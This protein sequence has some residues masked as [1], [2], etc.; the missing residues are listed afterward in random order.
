MSNKS[1][2]KK[3]TRKDI[4]FENLLSSMNSMEMPEGRS[5]DDTWNMLLDNIEH[6][7]TSKTTVRK[8]PAKS[9]LSIAASVIIIVGSWIAYNNLHMQTY[10]AGFGQITEVILP[11][12]SQVKLNAGT[13]IKFNKNRWKNNRHILINGEALFIVTKGNKFSVESDGKMI[14]VLGTS[15]NVLSRDNRFEVQCYT[16]KVSVEISSVKPLLLEKGEAVKTDENLKTL[17]KYN[18]DAGQ[19]VKWTKGEFYFNQEKLEYV[20]EEI[21]RQ[22]NVSIKSAEIKDRLYTGYFRKGSLKTALDIVCMPMGITYEM[23]D[24]THINIK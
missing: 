18:F 13:T 11:D 23:A 19:D 15:F 21:E 17:K 7:E 5:K 1:K 12:N 4:S 14:T 9:I 20:F 6:Q 24:S 2:Y 8:F 10:N 22:F 16:G 3:D